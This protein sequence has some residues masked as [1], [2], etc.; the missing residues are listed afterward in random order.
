MDF[1][2]AYH[3][4]INFQTFYNQKK[5]VVTG[6]CG[7]IGSHI[8]E[9]LVSLGAHVT[10]IDN[11]TTG[12]MANID[13]FKHK[14]TLI[15]KNI[16]SP[17]ACHEALAGNEIVFH[18]A[19]FVSVPGSVKD[20]TACHSTNIDGTYHILEAARKHHIKRVVFSSSSAV[21]GPREDRCSEDDTYLDP[22]SPYGIT[23]LVGELYCKQYTRH[24]HVPCVILRYFNVYGPRQNPHSMYAAAVA[25][26]QHH[27]KRNEPITI[28][29][30]GL[31]TRDFIH[32]NRVVEANLI[33]GMAPE[34]LVAGHVYNIASGR[35]ISILELVNQLKQEH[36]KYTGI[37][38]FSDA[39]VGDVKHTQADVHKYNQLHEQLF[40]LPVSSSVDLFTDPQGS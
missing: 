8:A 20:P 7:F 24:Y 23:K 2:T 12:S 26:F 1:Q 3:Q 18:L 40:K 22:L 38:Q 34:R 31:Q 32:V 36:P 15:T 28:F 5:V 37:I 19:A 39:R 33:T 13:H 25:T 27:M 9:R 4:E 14:I 11:L 10:I 17:E 29:G 30:D 35:S 16:E 6:G 21:Y